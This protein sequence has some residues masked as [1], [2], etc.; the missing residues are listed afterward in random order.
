M[1]TYKALNGPEL[2]YSTELFHEKANTPILRSSGELIL[3]KQDWM[4]L[5]LPGY[6][7]N[8]VEQIL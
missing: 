3:A 8:I 1:I 5:V 4:R 2:A 7:A 6:C